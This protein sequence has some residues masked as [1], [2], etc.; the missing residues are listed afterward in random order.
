MPLA[1]YW[2]NTSFHSATQVTPYEIVFGQ[3]PP[4]HLT[5]LPGEAKVAVVAKSLQER[6]D[7]LLILKFHLLRAQ[8]RMKQVADRHRSERSFELGDWV[9]V[10]LQPYR[11]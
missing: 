7:M 5:Y 10:K 2:Y 3:P 6:E 4:F 8:H 9:F 11:K 1:E